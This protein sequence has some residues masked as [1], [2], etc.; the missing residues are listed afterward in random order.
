MNCPVCGI[1]VSVEQCNMYSGVCHECEEK[2]AAARGEAK[3]PISPVLRWAG[4]IGHVLL[5]ALL[6]APVG[7][8]GLG[9]VG[10]AGL[11]ALSPFLAPVDFLLHRI[12][13]GTFWG[14]W[15][16]ESSF[17]LGWSSSAQ[18][19]PG[20]SGH[21]A[22]STSAALFS[23][24]WK[25]FPAFLLAVALLIP[26]YY[27]DGWR[28]VLIGALALGALIGAILSIVSQWAARPP[29]RG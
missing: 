16:G 11:F 4:R 13:W 29:R 15:P 23:E 10:L 17:Y 9:L 21:P 12:I 14:P 26:C 20:D 24:A 25:A 6:C 5:C 28:G 7:V 27:L 22:S 18:A 8:L 19:S 3:K 2:A 1:E